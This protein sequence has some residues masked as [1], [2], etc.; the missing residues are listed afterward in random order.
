M[1]RLAL[2]VNGFSL[3]AAR[4]VALEPGANDSDDW[5]VADLLAGLID[6]SMVVAEPT[7]PPR[8]RLLET[9]RT[10][11]RDKLVA[12][13]ELSMIRPRVLDWLLDFFADADESAWTTPDR[14][15]VANVRPELANLRPVVHDALA[16]GNASDAAVQV[17]AAALLSWL[18]LGEAESEARALADRALAL[19]G[20]GTA[21]ATEARL[22]LD[23]ACTTGVLIF[24]YQCRRFSA[25]CTS[26]RGSLEHGSRA[27]PAGVRARADACR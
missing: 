5:A 24:T 4:V 26:P 2:F 6:K 17:V 27:Y 9:V 23:G 11:A 20:D 15:W 3:D 25:R 21:R 7:E 14:T 1:R 19:I 16:D 18:R 13:G 22:Q 8:Y 10:Y 12:A